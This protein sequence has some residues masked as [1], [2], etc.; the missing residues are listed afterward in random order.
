MRKIFLLLGCILISAF[1][2]ATVIE[3]SLAQR[4][5]NSLIVIEGK[6]VARSGFWNASHSMIYTD[7]DVEIYKIFKG[8]ISVSHISIITP[9]GIIGNQMIVQTPSSELS[10]GNF[11]IF[12]IQSAS[13]ER[14][15][16]YDLVRELNST[17]LYNPEYSF[18]DGSVHF[19]S[20][21]ELYNKIENILGSFT[22]LISF[23]S[24]AFTSRA[25]VTI[26]GFSPTSIT[27]GTGNILTITGRGFGATQGS[28][29]VLFKNAASGGYTDD[30]EPHSSQYINWSD[31]VITLRVPSY[32]ASG[33]GGTAGTGTI[34]V[35]E[36]MGG[37]ATSV[38]TLTVL[39]S[40]TNLLSGGSI[41]T[42]RLVNDNA[43][44]GYFLKLNNLISSNPNQRNAFNRA[45]ETWRCASLVNFNDTVA[46]TTIV[47]GSLDGLNVVS[48][49]SLGSPYILG[50]CNAYYL[51]CSGN[52]Y[53]EEFDLTFNND[54]SINWNYSSSL[55]SFTQTDFESIALN[56]LGFAHQ[57]KNVIDS[58]D[59]MNAVINNGEALRILNANNQFGASL[60]MS[61]STVSAPCGPVAMIPVSNCFAGQPNDA[62]LIAISNP[63]NGFCNGTFP[64]NVSVTNLGTSTLTSLQINWKINGIAQTPYTW[65]GSLAH[66]DT[67]N[68]IT[69]GSYAFIAGAY[70][71]DASTSA[72]NIGIDGYTDNDS[73]HA[74]ITIYS[75]TSSDA[76]VSYII[77]PT[78]YSCDGPNN[79]SVYFENHGA[80]IL[81][82]VLLGWSINGILQPTY[83]WAGTLTFG[84]SSSV[85]LGTA[86]LNNGDII[87]M[88]TNNPNGLADSNPLNDT[89]TFTFNRIRLNGTYTIGGITPN[90]ATIAAAV[91]D[92]NTKGICSDV[93][94][95]IRNGTYTESVSLGT[96]YN[97]S[98]TSR[99][100][101]QSESGDSTAVIINGGFSPTISLTGTTYITFR[102]L[103][104]TTIASNPF[105]ISTNCTNISIL[106]N[107]I[108]GAT[109]GVS[110]ACIYS[111]AVSSN[112]SFITIANNKIS[113]GSDGIRLIAGIAYVIT[114]LD[115]N[116]NIITNQPHGIGL[117][118]T[119]SASVRKNTIMIPFTASSGYYGISLS[120][121]TGAYR[122][123]GN[124]IVITSGKGISL[125][126]SNSLPTHRGLVCNNFISGGDAINSANGIYI[127]DVKFCNIYHN[128]VNVMANTYFAA[129]SILA[130]DSLEG[131]HVNVKNN[132]FKNGGTGYAIELNSTSGMLGVEPY[133][134]V[135]N[136]LNNNAYSYAGA[137]FTRTSYY[138][139]PSITA[140]QTYVGKDSASFCFAPNFVSPTDL[141]VSVLS[142]N[143]VLNGSAVALPEV[144][145]DIDGEIRST[146]NPD[147]GADEFFLANT[148]AGIDSTLETLRF[149]PGIN[150]VYATVRNFGTTVLNTVTINWSVNA[151][152]QAPLIVA[153][154]LTSGTRSAFMNIGAI[155]CTGGST[156][157]LK[158]WT[159]NPNGTS[160]AL[161][162]ND[163]LTFSVLAKGL[164]G[165][166][167][168]GGASPDYPT[169]TDAKNALNAQG[170]CGPVIFKV[171]NGTYTETIA[172]AAVTGT[173]AYNT[174][175]F[176]SELAD[177]SLVSLNVSGGLQLNA[178]RYFI[179]SKMN[180]ITP[181]YLNAASHITIRNNRL[182]SV[183][184]GINTI[185]EYNVIENNYLP[186]GFVS[187]LG[188]NT[189]ET[190]FF[191]EKNN[192][193]RNNYFANCTVS[194]IKLFYQ[195]N[196]IVDHNT[197]IFND[198]AMLYD[199]YAIELLQTTTHFEITKNTIKG[200]PSMGIL[201]ESVFVSATNRGLISNNMISLSGANI[202]SCI[203]AIGLNHTDILY[204]S[205]RLDTNAGLYNVVLALYNSSYTHEPISKDVRIFNN[206]F[207]N[208]S[209]GQL[210]T[211]YFSISNFSNFNNW[212]GLGNSLLFGLGIPISNTLNDWQFYTGKDLNSVSVDPL[213]LS[214][215]NLHINNN[216]VLSSA[217]TPMT[218]V[219]KD[220]DG[221]IRSITAP[222]IGADEYN[223]SLIPNDAGIS[224][225]T[226][227]YPVCHGLHNVTVLLKNY[228]STTL[229][230]CT[231]NWKVNGILQT[232]FLWTGSLS[233]LLGTSVV[234][235]SYNFNANSLY[236]INAWTTLPNGIA[237]T[238][239]F[240]DEGIYNNIRPELSGTYT[241]G[242]STPD[243]IN[244][245]TATNSLLTNG[246]CGPVVFNVRNGTYAEKIILTDIAGSSAVNTVTFQSESGDSSSVILQSTDD[247]E[248]VKIDG[249]DFLTFKKMT[250]AANSWSSNGTIILINKESG[251]LNFQNNHFLCTSSFQPDG[252]VYSRLFTYCPNVQFENNYFSG[253]KMGINLGTGG[254]SPGLL[255]A[256]N[257]FADQFYR[258]VNLI[259]VDGFTLINNNFQ[260]SE[261]GIDI[262]GTITG[263]LISGNKTSAISQYALFIYNASGSIANPGRIYNNFFSSAYNGI[264]N[265]GSNNVRFEFNNIRTTSTSVFSSSAAVYCFSATGLDFKNNIIAQTGG[266]YAMYFSSTGGVTSDYN[267]LYVTGPRF[268]H[269]GFSDY[270]NLT[271]FQTATSRDLNSLSIDPLFFSTD[272]LHVY[273]N[274]LDNRGISVADI[275][276]D[277]D[278]ETRNIL[279]PDIGADEKDFFAYD[280]QVLQYAQPLIPCE[281]INP[282]V[283]TIKNNAYLP[284]NTVIINWEMNGV[285]QTPYNWAG[286]VPVGGTQLITI[287]TYSFTS[288]SINTF[289][290]WT[291][292]PNGNIDEN[293]TNDTVAVSNIKTAM[294]GT[295]TIG[296]S[297]PDYISFTQAINDLMNFGICGNVVFNVRAGIY[298]E[299]LIIPSITGTSATDTILFQSE[300]G[301]S[302]L[303][304]LQYN[305]SAV[306][307]YVINM[308]AT[309]HITF[310]KITIEALNTSYANVLVIMGNNSNI[311]VYNSCLKSMA[312]SS[313]S[314]YI[315]LINS[316]GTINNSSFQNNKFINGD[317]GIY[318]NNTTGSIS[319]LNSIIGNTFID[320]QQISI[321]FNNHELF[322]IRNN[323]FNSIF[324]EWNTAISLDNCN[325]NFSIQSNKILMVNGTGMR[326][327]TC[328]SGI[329]INNFIHAVSGVSLLE[330]RGIYI[331]SCTL[332]NVY[333]NSVRIDGNIYGYGMKIEASIN[334]Q[335][336]N[337]IFANFGKGLAIQYQDVTGLIA[338][339]NSLY[340]IDT[341][342]SYILGSATNYLN[343]IPSITTATS[344]YE[345][346]SVEIVPDFVSYNDLHIFSNAFLDAKGVVLPLVSVDIDNQLRDTP[347]DIG[348]DEFMSIPL[349]AGPTD[350]SLSADCS[351][352]N[353]NMK[354]GNYG[355]GVLNAVTINWSV[356]SIMQTPYFWSG[357]LATATMSPSIIIGTYPFMGVSPY[358]VLIW[359]SA[360]NGS[361]DGY[362]LNDTLA[363]ITINLTQVSL[364]ND[365]SICQGGPLVLNPANSFISY[366][367]SDGS[368]GSS[369]VVSDSG[370][371]SVICVNSYGCSSADSVVVTAL[372]APAIPLITL[373]GG[374]LTSSASSSN[375]WFLNGVIIPG[376]T[377]PTYT[378]TA[379]GYYSV[380]VMGINGCTSSSSV[381]AI[382]VGILENNDS[383]VNYNLFPNPNNGNFILNIT[384]SNSNEEV[385]L[386]VYSVLGQN[387]FEDHFIVNENEFN[388]K[389]NLENIAN[390]IY[391]LILR[392]GNLNT[393]IRFIVQ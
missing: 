268:I 60:V 392:G 390:G 372:P 328:T 133:V 57:L 202:Q 289:R 170:I 273:N 352:S 1:S 26:S 10:V 242:G 4:I 389:M 155:A 32:N 29:K 243:Y 292:M 375:Q 284:L 65:T 150:D 38:Q 248:T 221:D 120:I 226:D 166:Y 75:C 211:D 217:A 81:H 314:K 76:S 377:S 45:L 152:L 118:R 90:Y 286:T 9:G 92:L 198:L 104:I 13:R 87:K 25:T 354:V 186:A 324:P 255:I 89:M 376:A 3:P 227:V 299:Q 366:L 298:N 109:G 147:I 371:Y 319:Q 318:H 254:G 326:L 31:T 269:I 295:F 88:W 332:V 78:N 148:D 201:L 378:P 207:S 187:F 238:S 213:F 316:S 5:N 373:S 329:I 219:L 367:W 359:T 321:Y 41:V 189:T 267:D 153:T 157:T 303:V 305:A 252:M 279:T 323:E 23:T 386:S 72:P 336:I 259:S 149:C 11:G 310:K 178:S 260:N 52:W 100:T 209:L 206:I 250:L 185:E 107:V 388:K 220:I 246:V 317:Y 308:N 80:S 85:T 128:T 272:D 175:E 365:T 355:T 59:V 131:E 363:N 345:T 140:W 188:T 48:M 15:A 287:G 358:N 212:Y 96:I 36:D 79:I 320:Q 58:S 343:D 315:I 174:I 74:N 251:Y 122:I 370:T 44:G 144:T 203:R 46:S 19:N 126:A 106:N 176:T 256:N 8:T 83:T 61:Q 143:M 304:N 290:S 70:T 344:G 341:L 102:K 348:A 361:I 24:R 247:Y 339:N 158:I 119:V 333:N 56:L 193:V 115:I 135:V 134:K 42:P 214:P 138:G 84:V 164:S 105:L 82:Y 110:T 6:V 117:A 108:Q 393:T 171:R 154:S 301:D 309:S 28:G 12:F 66:H 379:S 223:L 205:C 169:F 258:G 35:Q 270:I 325:A 337:N 18:N 232:P 180:L 167:T 139:I 7:N 350:F 296:G 381:I 54:T 98:P 244:F 123:E 137:I 21:N 276:A 196:P 127:E 53:L 253:G 362:T 33:T 297:T 77:N 62:S 136:Q 37:A 86:I 335:L 229:N 30:V 240:N 360:P 224:L 285:P 283:V 230:S 322:A 16:S 101:F 225:I 346:N 369:L 116:N 125:A 391:F 241:I 43:S 93:I 69:I 249:A 183:I 237:D 97:S 145:T 307:N 162:L 311:H 197:I 353:V 194:G 181:V 356:N 94:F 51:N 130:H 331:S 161:A 160:D 233:S 67:L 293:F 184:S 113:N 208:Y 151:V 124:R 156:Y 280:A 380:V 387:I 257:Y 173:S 261:D 349:D 351:N 235:G 294:I 47:G 129:L 40:R 313:G 281:G 17:I 306:N 263:Y 192:V 68:N 231:I 63:Y 141:H 330:P 132:I 179:F 300:L 262:N 312:S 91:T 165:T 195:E 20:K 228:G 274:L 2:N 342:A 266:G 236:D 239:N 49:D 302:A 282:I 357:T 204:N 340:A 146:L 327:R 222:D 385:N 191:Q 199:N 334:T 177:S 291:S 200:N 275:F 121:E 111:N 384:N 364:S 95:N 271:D 288:R 172:F 114:N 374:V 347:P 338:N 264:Y 182:S 265:L 14:V 50:V 55:P 168:I 190:Y 210:Y 71:I 27:A 103:T 142:P 22:K 34:I 216:Y 159:S 112:L 215:I 73:L 163:T 218:M 234:L 39:F 245:T 99:I 64:V 277:I 278:N 383:T 368:T 382:G